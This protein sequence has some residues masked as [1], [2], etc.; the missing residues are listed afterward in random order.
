MWGCSW[1]MLMWRLLERGTL[2]ADV[3]EGAAVELEAELYCRWTGGFVRNALEMIWLLECFAGG[4]GQV[5]ARGE[6]G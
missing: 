1:H 5:G 4:G 6:A 3:A 2:L